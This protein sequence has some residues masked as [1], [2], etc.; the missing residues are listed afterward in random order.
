MSTWR[1][2]PLLALTLL[3]S[4]SLAQQSMW[5]NVDTLNRRTC[6]SEGCGAVGRIFFGQKVEVYETSGEW[7]RVS[8]PYDASCVAGRSLYVDS[9]PTGCEPRNGIIDGKFAE[10]VAKQYLTSTEPIDPAASAAAD[11]R[12]VA[13]SDHFGTHRRAFAKAAGELVAQGQC[14][15]ADF[16]E[17]GGWIKSSNQPDAPIYF[18]YCRGGNDR[19]YLDASSGRIF[20]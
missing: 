9:G 20:R 16:L 12:L 2:L 8:Q 7:A 3:P 19:I 17:W 6:P 15:E 1:W 13:N 18:T 5:V 10:W 4:A 14:T 11:E